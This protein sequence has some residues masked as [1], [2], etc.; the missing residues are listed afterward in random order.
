MQLQVGYGPR[1]DRNECSVSLLVTNMN[2]FTSKSTQHFLLDQKSKSSS[3][4]WLDNRRSPHCSTLL[5]TKMTC[6]KYGK[7]YK[8]MQFQHAQTWA[9]KLQLWKKLKLKEGG[10][11]NDQSIKW[12]HETFQSLSMVD[13]PV[14]EKGRIVYLLASLPDSYYTSYSSGN[15]VREQWSLV[16]DRKASAP[17]GKNEGERCSC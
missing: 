11:V 13:A 17:R 12:M 14:S 15:A 5:S 9:N 2:C 6:A 10:S 7:Q 8:D 16:T 4:N 3:S 1:P